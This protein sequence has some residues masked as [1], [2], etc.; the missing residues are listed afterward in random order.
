M[1]PPVRLREADRVRALARIL[2]SAVRVP[3]TNIRF[4]LDALIGLI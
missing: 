1:T 3:G 2:D 4:G